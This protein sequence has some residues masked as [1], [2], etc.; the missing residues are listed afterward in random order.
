MCLSFSSTVGV[1]EPVCL[2]FSSTADVPEP[3]CLSL[4][5]TAGVPEAMACSSQRPR[6]R[7][8]RETE[9]IR[10]PCGKDSGNLQR[11]LTLLKPPRVPVK[12]ARGLLGVRLSSHSRLP[13]PRDLLWAPSSVSPRP[14]APRHLGR[15]EHLSSGCLLHS[16]SV[17][18]P[19][20]STHMM[21]SVSAHT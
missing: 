20:V 21:K 8:M 6:E 19:S 4:S 17:L 11:S 16:G 7:Q 9:V 15:E 1:A 3:V 2:T 12:G 5:N 13:H 10:G 18:S 14:P